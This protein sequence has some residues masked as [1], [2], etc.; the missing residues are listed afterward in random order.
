MIKLDKKDKKLLYWLDQNSRATNKELGKKVGLTEQ[1]IGYKI[2]RL[3]EQEIIR[4]FVT[5]VNTLSLGYNHYK[6][7]LKLHNTTENIEKII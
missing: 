4:K 3:Q 7:F 5:F 6:I 2:K 1:S